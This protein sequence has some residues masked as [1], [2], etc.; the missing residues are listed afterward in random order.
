MFRNY[1]AAA[2]RN[3]AR[4]RFYS[5]ISVVALAIG[6]CAA[7]LTGLLIRNQLTF[8]HFV[9]GYERTYLASAV[10]LPAGRAPLYDRMA[11]SWVAALLKL[12]F[13]D[14][15]AVTRLADQDVR[16]RRGLVESKEKIYW[17]DKSVFDVLPLPVFRGDLNA[18]L[19]RPDGIVLPRNIARKYFG[20]DNPIG[21]SILVDGA[22]PLIVTAVIEDLPSAGTQLESGIFASGAASYSLLSKWDNDPRNNPKSPGLSL[23]GRTY[24]RLA[25]NASIDRLQMA[26]PAFVKGFYPML[27][28]GLGAS[29]QFIRIDQVSLFPGLNPGARSRLA[30]IAIVGVLILVIACLV[31]INLSTA[32]S[33]R[34]AVEVG[35]RKVLGAN[36][37]TLVLQFL[38]E[39]LIHVSMAAVL[40]AAVTELLIPRVN[41][42]L[43]SGAVFDY[44]RDP[45]LLAWMGM[46]VI[47]VGILA[48]AYPAFVLSAF[49][50]VRVLKGSTFQSGGA[51]ARQCL[52][53]LQ[54]AILIGLLIAAAVVYQQRI[55]ATRDAL[56]V[57]AD[58]MLIIRSPC[59]SAFE[60]E[61]RALAG[62]RGAFCSADALLSGVVFGNYRLKDGSVE[63]ID[64]VGAE[65]GVLD[66]YGL[67]PLAGRFSSPQNGNDIPSA[68]RWHFVINEAA[69][70]RFGFASPGA[71]IGQALPFVPSGD[72]SLQPAVAT[73]IVGV[74]PDFS[75]HAVEHSVKPAVYY[76]P[77]A[78][79][80]D[81]ALRDFQLIN[82]KL[83][84]RDIP[85]TLEVI[86]R[87][88][89]ATG[90][91]GPVDRFFLNDY[92]QS[93]YLTML[94]EAQ[95]FSVF[96]GVA[97]L[98]AC[99]G[100]VGLSASAT[101]RRTKEIGIR[102]AMG[103]GSGD[104]VRLLVWELTKPVL[105][106]NAI[107]WPAAAFFLNG[108][109]HG[110]AYHVELQPWLFVA[111]TALAL[112][113]ALLTV[114]VQCYRVARD[115]P[116]AALRY[117]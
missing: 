50:P 43:N 29:L 102:K 48:G 26:M 109:L 101:E 99:L 62:V 63:A 91:S 114:S 106:A 55:Y 78:I 15:E 20:R 64:M 37:G 111:A 74:V 69:A 33:A 112:L 13:E 45:S 17:A 9:R 70:R 79:Y 19:R 104:I 85:E 71:A 76:I 46:G 88:W 16:L 115:K 68:T 86:D 67:K 28:P 58:Q 25:L 34:R 73:E 49:R 100:L 87:L 38:G 12:N 81:V 116:I 94:R 98:L 92:I 27:P 97:V 39:S 18:A 110:F 35:V 83:A 44:W 84:G 23:G 5:G 113:V 108:W 95:A 96:S 80:G 32:R 51:V 103:A 89:S 6:L 42:F 90:G 4:N 11:P 24:L 14:I 10:L 7:L 60:T 30:V 22:H 59:N 8:D 117:E 107:A 54:F 3:L 57:N 82:V 53:A 1:L 93:L 31:F 52:V 21:E 105:W 40:A 36:R 2:L 47:T 61:V 77:S 72:G 66:L 56:R 75:I 65:F 41:T